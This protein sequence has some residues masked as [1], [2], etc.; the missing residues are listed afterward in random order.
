[1][2]VSPPCSEARSVLTLFA[3]A[4]RGSVVIHPLVKGN[5]F[6]CLTI[7]VNNLKH[8]SSFS[9]FLISL[10]YPVQPLANANVGI[11]DQSVTNGGPGES[12]SPEA[13]HLT[14]VGVWGKLVDSLSWGLISSVQWDDCTVQPARLYNTLDG[15][16]AIH[17]ALIVLSLAGVGEEVSTLGLH[18]SSI[19]S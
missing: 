11:V 6:H 7:F 13:G 18:A 19:N 4:R 10:L 15:T 8:S 2:H 16:Q 9:S 3:F 17:Q 5:W 1:M 14:P 12:N